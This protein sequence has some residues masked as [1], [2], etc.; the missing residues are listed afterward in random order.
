MSYN[1]FDRRS[2]IKKTA[3]G[4]IGIG[5]TA[6]ETFSL[7]DHTYNLSKIKEY[8]RMGRTNAMVSDIGSGIPYSESVL[9]AVIASGV[10][11]IETA[12]SYDNGR[13][14]LL[15]GDVINRLEREKL[16][17]TTKVNLSTGLATSTDE[18]I[19]SAEGSLRRLKTPYI[20]LY[21]MHQAQSIVKVADKSFHK[22][23]DR[24]KKE[25]KIRFRG[26]SCHGTFWWQEQGSSLEDILMAAIEDGR[27]DVLFFPYN[28]L[29]PGMGE[30]IIRACKAKDIG[31]MIMKSN[32]V[33]VLEDYE[34]ILNRGDKLDVFEQKDYERK[35]DQLEK[36]SGFLSR[37]RLSNIEELKKAAYRYILSNQGVGTICCR[38][39]NFSDIEFFAGISGTRLDSSSGMLLSDFRESLGFLNC[40]IGCSICEKSC[41]GHIPVNT[42][43]RYYYYAQILKET[44]SASEY[45]HNLKIPNKS[46]CNGC[47]GFCEK[48]CPHKVAVR[49]LLNEADRS[50]T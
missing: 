19:R 42:I 36:A 6:N 47:P 9:K 5:L 41:P 26:L 40:R 12:E 10:N 50:L 24:L 28:F 48:S 45:Y 17:I 33:G 1:L 46:D 7:S 31:T 44:D 39:R 15:I 23:C 25:G 27:Y 8:R 20:D 30:R 37:Y 22:A 2:F 43:M 18:I 38:F 13:N 14:E 49:I 32:P 34:R 3:A 29:D 11:F 21:M 4:A 16:F 35:K